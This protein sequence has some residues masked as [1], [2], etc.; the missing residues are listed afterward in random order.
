M[1]G[2]LSLVAP[3][4]DFY[5]ATVSIR[6]NC[7]QKVYAIVFPLNENSDSCYDNTCEATELGIDAN[8]TAPTYKTNYWLRVSGGGAKFDA[9]PAGYTPVGPNG[10]RPT[11]GSQQF[12]CTPAK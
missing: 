3:Q 11:S 9:C 12:V 10:Q 7:P 2:C 4:D 5:G 1:N 8:S 6:N